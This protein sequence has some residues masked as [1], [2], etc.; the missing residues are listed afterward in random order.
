MPTV[1]KV[2]HYMLVYNNS[3]SSLPYLPYDH[4][5]LI[6]V[7]PVITQAS[8]LYINVKIP[9]YSKELARL[10]SSIVLDSSLLKVESN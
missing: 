2:G 8:N 1:S 10:V 5:Q 3:S 7:I 4:M 9:H 6:P